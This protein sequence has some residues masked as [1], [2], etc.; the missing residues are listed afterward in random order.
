MQICQSKARTISY[1]MAIVI[2]TYLSSFPRYLQSEY[3]WSWPWPL[4]W[5]AVMLIKHQYI[6]YYL[7]AIVMF[8]I[9]VTIQGYSLFK[10]AWPWHSPLQWFKFI[11]KYAIRKS[12]Y[13]LPFNDCSN[14]CHIC[15]RL[16]D[17][18]IWTS[19][20]SQIRIFDLQR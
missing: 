17:N 4:K 10:C 8:F 20:I 14:I 13:N 15:Y 5:V 19:E 7:M 18:H 3:A 9:P 11:C 12:I 1:F 2:L 6:N 16:L